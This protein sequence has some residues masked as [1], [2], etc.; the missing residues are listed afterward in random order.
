MGPETRLRVVF[1]FLAASFVVTSCR[2]A[3]RVSPVSASPII[4]AAAV[5]SML[6]AEIASPSV[7]SDAR[8]GPA[9]VTF[10]P[11]NEPFDFRQRLEN[12][13]LTVLRA[14]TSQTYVNLEGGGVWIA[15]YIRYRVFRCS[16]EV[17]V[18]S[19]MTE[20]D[21]L[22]GVIPPTCGEPPSGPVQF[23]PR[24][25]PANFRLQLEAKYRDGLRAA[26]IQTAVD[27]E[28]DVV[29][30]QQYY[31]YR[32]NGCNHEQASSKTLIN[33]QT[34]QLQAFCAPDPPPPP[35]QNPITVRLD[36]PSGAV[37]ANRDLSFS[38]LRS[39]ST[40]GSIVSY[41]WSCGAA[42]VSNC[43]STSPTPT[44]RYP[45]EGRLGA[46]VI[47][48]VT[49]TVTDSAGNRRSASLNLNVSQVY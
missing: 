5:Q 34:Q 3:E 18:A 2:D 29:W 8:I 6:L 30:M 22:R 25:E 9:A 13:Y 42:N 36:G 11:N 47:Y 17:A 10:P 31:L 23:P 44:F 40:A 38:G 35:P 32:L 37:N 43:N 20:I 1:L 21:T 26:P 46:T 33:I 39:S 48:V 19:V 12:F 28:G 15:E 4:N 16:H 7:M 41:A 14:P 24:N 49:L 45:K 27:I